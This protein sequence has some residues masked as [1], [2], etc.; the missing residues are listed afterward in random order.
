MALMPD[1]GH[2]TLFLP[3]TSVWARVRARSARLVNSGDSRA[4]T[5]THAVTMR[6]RKDVRPG[7]RIVYRGRALEVVEAEDINGRRAY[8]AC[9]CTETAVVG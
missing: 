3:V 7:D 2:E 6:F 1:G 4:A 5:S 9:L 8:L